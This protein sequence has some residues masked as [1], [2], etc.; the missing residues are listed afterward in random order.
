MRPQFAPPSPLALRRRPEA[1]KPEV[2]KGARRSRTK[3][4]SKGAPEAQESVGGGCLPF[5]AEVGGGF[6]D[7]DVGG[8]A[9]SR[10]QRADHAETEGAL[11]VEDFGNLA[12]AL[13]VG[14][15]VAGLEPELIHPKANGLNRIRRRN[16]LVFRFI[17]LDEE[18]PEF[19]RLLVLTPRRSVHQRLHLLQ[20]GLV[21]GRGAED[22][23]IHGS[24]EDEKRMKGEG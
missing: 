15:E 22:F 16:G 21:V 11:A 5:G 23:R 19:E 14:R 20:G 10:L 7:E 24:K 3:T 2:S 12:F 1:G 9:E 4:T 18:S 8:D 13:N 6:L 17:I